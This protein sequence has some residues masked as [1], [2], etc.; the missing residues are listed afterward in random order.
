LIY[1]VLGIF[2]VFGLWAVIFRRWQSGVMLLLAYLPFAGAVTLSQYPSSLP[3][4]F[5]DFFFV[6]P[7]YL[8]FALT[9]R[10]GNSRGRVPNG[11]LIAMLVLAEMV[12][13]QSFN[14]D[15]PN[16]MVAAIGAKVWLFY[17]PL[18][19]L[20]FAML[21]SAGDLINVLRL[22]AVLAWIPCCVGI[23]QW[24][25][26]MTFGYVAT[27]TFFYGEAAQG[28]TQG[29]ASFDVGGEFFRIPS[30]FTFVTQYFGFTLA[31]IAIAY[32]LKN[33]DT[34]AKW[35]KFSEATMW[36]V[37][38]ASFMSGARAAYLFVPILLVLIYQ[39]EGKLG[40]MLK[41]TVMLPVA[42]LVAM[43][44]AGIDPLKMFDMTQEL[45]LNYSDE[46]AKK[47]LLDALQSAPFGTGTGM[48]T[49]PARY[50]FD[51][52]ET[53]IGIENY[54]AKAVVEMGIAGLAAVAGLFIVL[55]VHGYRIH[56][57]LKDAGLRSC[58]AAFLGFI[59]MMVLNSFKGWQI[60]L[61]P[62]N[63]YF[64]VFAGFMLKLEYLDQPV[65]PARGA[66]ENGPGF[67]ARLP[68]RT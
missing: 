66:E 43:A 68:Q 18:L 31:M 61:D 9:R 54:Y 62:V 1:W 35:R 2:V 26:S 19:Y 15:I 58:C 40:G 47:G 7:A 55:M 32:A 48:N 28:A 50:A 6:I 64:W 67:S 20:A 22:M 56:Q 10:G 46:I 27:M 33:V 23:L 59:I 11:V 38:V 5:K 39:L 8:A 53:L 29:F 13:I 65:Q 12:F 37:V 42:A 60:D 24:I 21:E 16:W 52:P 4:L 3:T 63:V 45:F 34:S 14:S 41:I 30:T 17:L 57:R 49:G 25:A 51:D 36:L 44:F